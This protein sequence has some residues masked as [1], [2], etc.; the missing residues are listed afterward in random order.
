MFAPIST[1]S[2]PYMAPNVNP[3]TKVMTT[4]GTPTVV[5]NA[6]RPMNTRGAHQK[7][8]MESKNPSIST[9]WT[10]SPSGVKL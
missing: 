8:S 6:Y 7:P 1:Y 5:S 2:V 4:M 10:Y 3:A 9:G